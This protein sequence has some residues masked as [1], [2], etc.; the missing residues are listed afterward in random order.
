MKNTIKSMALISLFA[1]LTTVGAYLK[2]PVPVVPFTFQVFFVSISGI[3]LGPKNGAFAQLL[4][5]IL[6]LIGIPVFTQGGGISY[7]FNPTFGY[8]IGFIGGAYLT[9]F[10]FQ[11][12]KKKTIG[13][14]FLAIL[15]GLAVIYSLGVVHLYVI[16]KFYLANSF[17]LW[18]AIYYGFILCIGGDILSSYLAAVLCK[19]LF[20]IQGLKLPAITD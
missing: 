14:I 20:S 8:I 3:L 16:Q 5:A 9:G 11:K 2:V 7:I 19:K 15:G 12:L 17:T 18:N 10:L 1:A 4:Y 6:G 13:G